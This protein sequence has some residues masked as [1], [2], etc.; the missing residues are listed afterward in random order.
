M[1]EIRY[2]AK[3]C[4][5]HY[6]HEGRPYQNCGTWVME[7][8]DEGGR[9]R[10]IEAETITEWTGCRDKKGI[11]IFEGDVLEHDDG[12]LMLIEFIAPFWCIS[13]LN[14]L[15]DKD[16]L[17]DYTA[18]RFYKVIGNKFDNPELVRRENET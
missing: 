18:T 10:R 9:L 13:M 15:I 3:C 11:R 2:R 14:G 1:R 12:R 8:T 17:D 7:C 6:W 16:V 4:H 5:D